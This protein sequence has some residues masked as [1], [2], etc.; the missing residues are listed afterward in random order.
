MKAGHSELDGCSATLPAMRPSPR[1]PTVV[2][3]LPPPPSSL[4]RPSTHRRTSSNT[5]SAGLRRVGRVIYPSQPHLPHRLRLVKSC[6]VPYHALH[7]CLLPRPEH[8]SYLR[9]PALA[10]LSPIT[11]AASS[12]PRPIPNTPTH[13][14]ALHAVSTS[15]PVSP[16]PVSPVPRAPAASYLQTPPPPL[17]L[18]LPIAPF[19]PRLLR[20]HIRFLRHRPW[21]LL[22]ITPSP[23][24]VVQLL[25]RNHH[26]QFLLTP[27]HRLSYRP[28]SSF[29]HRFPQPLLLDRRPCLIRLYPTAQPMPRHFL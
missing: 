8:L 29:R 9:P 17:A 4:L 26:P 18:G 19:F 25:V 16:T 1:L 14:S 10:S 2:A 28:K 15:L 7:P 13:T 23:K 20:L 5:R 3:S 12:D 27:S 24:P 6:M 21:H 11:A 22:P